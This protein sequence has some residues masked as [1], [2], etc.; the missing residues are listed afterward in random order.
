MATTPMPVPE[1]PTPIS[2][3]GRV[4]GVFFSP[5]K[6]FADIAREPSWVLPLM[7]L[8]LLS[9]GVSIGINQR[10][11]WREFMSQQ[12]EKSPRA[13][14]LS[15]VQKE[16]Q[17]EAGAKIS[18]LFT[19]AVGA[20]GPAIFILIIT[21]IMWGSYNLFAGANTNFATSFGITSHAFLTGLVSSPLFFLVLYLK[22]LG[23]VDL[24]NP[25]AANVAA[26]LPEDSAKWLL[27]L[28]RQLDLFAIWTL[29]LLAIGFSTVNPK[30]LK[31]GT[32]YAIAFG[33][34]GAWVALR[35]GAAFI[36]S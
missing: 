28:G 4:I 14:D 7:L 11:N 31:G 3:F 10:V 13:A 5:K 19:Y 27:T 8:T 12:I 25:V 32:S 33:V 21:L 23:T 24:E 36:F 1:A 16:Q 30:K 20:C 26:F 15:N 2:A 22:E 17:I 35:V 6:T 9:I 29:V 18:P 34:W